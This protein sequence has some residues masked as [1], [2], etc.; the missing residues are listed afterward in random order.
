MR[1]GALIAAPSGRAAFRYPFAPQDAL[2]LARYIAAAVPRRGEAP[3]WIVLDRFAAYAQRAVAV[4]AVSGW[5][6]TPSGS[7]VRVA[8][9]PN[10][11]SR[12]GSGRGPSAW[13]G[14]IEMMEAT[15]P[16]SNGAA[17][18]GTDSAPSSGDEAPAADDTAPVSGDAPADAADSADATP[19]RPVRPVRPARPVRRPPI[20]RRIGT[21]ASG[22]RRIGTLRSRQSGRR[23]PVFGGRAGGKPYRIITR[24]RGGMRFE[25]MAVRSGQLE[26]EL[27]F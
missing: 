5:L 24:P 18:A 10:D 17:P 13:R 25:I 27:T 3:V 22:A 6:P 20:A 1:L 9:L 16:A 4:A 15:T 12:A 11:R 21:L 26:P 8:P 7:S 19:V 23:Y 2:W 14:E